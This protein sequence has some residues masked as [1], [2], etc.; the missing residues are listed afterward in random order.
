MCAELRSKLRPFWLSLFA[1]ITQ[2]GEKPHL[3]ARGLSTQHR[4]TKGACL[5]GRAFEDPTKGRVYPP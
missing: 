3:G 4:T 5:P 1:A 2:I